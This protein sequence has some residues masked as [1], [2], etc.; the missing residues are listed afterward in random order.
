MFLNRAMRLLSFCEIHVNDW[1][2]S[3]KTFKN[4]AGKRPIDNQGLKMIEIIL[5]QFYTPDL[6]TILFVT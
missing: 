3:K 6:H 4:T 2:F 1:N 5:Y